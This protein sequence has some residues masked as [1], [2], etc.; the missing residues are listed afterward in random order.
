M[1]LSFIRKQVHEDRAG[2]PGPV[3]SHTANTLVLEPHSN[4]Q[5]VVFSRR[6]GLRIEDA[7]ATGLRHGDLNGFAEFPLL[8]EEPWVVELDPIPAGQALAVELMD[9]L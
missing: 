3:I 7:G 9:S 8:A 4:L 2:I 6:E 1:H 5:G